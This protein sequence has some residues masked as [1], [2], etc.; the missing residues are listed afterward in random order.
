MP[1]ADRGYTRNRANNYNYQFVSITSVDAT[2]RT[3][4]GLTR[5]GTLLKIDTGHSVGAVLTTPSLG[6]QWTVVQQNGIWMLQNKLKGYDSNQLTQAVQGQ[7][8]IGSSNGPVE[9]NATMVNVNAPLNILSVT[10]AGRPAASSVPSGTQI[11][12]STLGLPIW[13]NGAV[14]HNAAGAT[15]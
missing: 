1:T 4:S 11:Y 9:L 8:I 12:D 10:T 7:Q 3:A 13:S 6:E 5:V 15:V 2:S 14:W